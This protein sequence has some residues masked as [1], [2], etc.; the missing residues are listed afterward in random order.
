M[1]GVW[2]AQPGP[3]LLPGTMAP[4]RTS[5]GI[6]RRGRR[7][8]RPDRPGAGL[9]LPGP[10]RS[11]AASEAGRQ[12]APARSDPAPLPLQAAARG[13]CGPGP[14][15]GGSNWTRQ[16]GTEGCWAA[17]GPD[18]FC[19]PPRGSLEGD[20]APT[21]L[22]PLAPSGTAGLTWSACTC[23]GGTGLAHLR[24]PTP[25]CS[26]DVP[27]TAMCWGPSSSPETP[28]QGLT[29]TTWVMSAA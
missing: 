8:L 16:P 24:L 9:G 14:A 28:P 29:D 22:S 18:V 13:R 26:P 19:P 2:E 25:F 6:L 15:S 3:F 17:G 12:G 20:A 23:L 4:A 11:T 1:V 21:G 7:H 10:R 27:V 5:R